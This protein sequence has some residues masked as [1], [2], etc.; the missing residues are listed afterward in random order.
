MSKPYFYSVFLA[1]IIGLVTTI[2]IMHTFKAAQPALLYLVP[3]CLGASS[4]MA[5]I[6]GEFRTLW[7]YS[8]E[9][10]QKKKQQQQQPKQQPTKQSQTKQPQI[11]QQLPPK[12]KNNKSTDVSTKST[13]M[14][15]ENSTQLKENNKNL[16]NNKK[17]TNVKTNSTKK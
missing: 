8:E 17:I 3:A 13:Q 6:R 11:K 7:N 12:N 9:E 14:K 5:Y 1:Y 4:L 2:F 10:K 15:K 16:K